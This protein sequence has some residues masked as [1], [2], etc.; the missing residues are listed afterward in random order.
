MFAGLEGVRMFWSLLNAHHFDKKPDND[1]D[2]E[3]IF[4]FLQLTRESLV[5]PRNFVSVLSTCDF[6]FFVLCTGMECVIILLRIV[7][8]NSKCPVISWQALSR[9]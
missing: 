7:V 6:S 4:I 9:V 2:D 3:D 5:W 1:D 8:T